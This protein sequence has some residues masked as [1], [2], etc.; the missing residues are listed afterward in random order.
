MCGIL[1]FHFVDIDNIYLIQ[2]LDRLYNGASLLILQTSIVF[3]PFL[4]ITLPWRTSFVWLYNSFTCGYHLH[5]RIISV[6]G[7]V[8]A[9]VTSL[10]QPPL[11]EVP[12]SNQ[13]RKGHALVWY[14]Y[15][16]FR[17]CGIFFSEFY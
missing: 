9:Y 1:V 12:V 16:L 13:E 6:R 5:D 7:E 8:W 11:T 17:W 4:N 15:R 3:I 10:T 14:G 2:V